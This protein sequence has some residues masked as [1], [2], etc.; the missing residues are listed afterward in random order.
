MDA[1]RIGVAI[2]RFFLRSIHESSNALGSQILQQI[3][4][5]WKTVFPLRRITFTL[6]TR[7]ISIEIRY[8]L[9]LGWLLT[10]S[11]PNCLGLIL[12]R[13]RNTGQRMNHFYTDDLKLYAS[14]E[15]QLEKLPTCSISCRKTS[16][17][18]NIRI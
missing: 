18:H 17:V 10:L 11:V 4:S 1:A 7:Q 13:K 2:E 6:T 8:L 14:C 3:I 5:R 9:F 15:Q 12:H 16:T